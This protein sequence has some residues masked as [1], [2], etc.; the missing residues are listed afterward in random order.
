MVVVHG[1][2]TQLLS[3]SSRGRVSATPESNALSISMSMTCQVE[4]GTCL[5]V[6]F[7][8]VEHCI[9]LYVREP[10]KSSSASGT[11]Q[12]FKVI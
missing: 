11:Q 2:G 4:A 7:V 8:V 6:P 9:S 10:S 5:A 3:A 12:N 1:V